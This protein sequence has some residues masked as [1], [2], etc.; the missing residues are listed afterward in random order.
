[1]RSWVLVL[2]LGASAACADGVVL[3]RGEGGHAGHGGQA[4]G[5]G[6]GG[7]PTGRCPDELPQ[8][9]SA[10]GVPDLLCTYG[11]DPR[12]QCRAMAYCM[13]PEWTVFMPKCI[14]PVSCEAAPPPPQ[15]ACMLEGEV[16]AYPDGTMCTC[17]TCFGGSC[18]MPGPSWYCTMLGPGCPTFVPNSGDVCDREGQ[19]CSYGDPCSSGV[20]AV[21]KDGEWQWQPIACPQ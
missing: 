2:A 14:G 18:T 15:A 12:P 8:G 7:E 4:G 10:C 11:D 5:G 19:A 1:M 17:A 13:W 21:C 16:C 6:Q 9:G 20:E 3:M